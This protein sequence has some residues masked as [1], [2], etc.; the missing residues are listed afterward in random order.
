MNEIEIIDSEKDVQPNDLLPPNASV[1]EKRLSALTTS[2]TALPVDVGKLWD[3]QNCQE[4]FLP[5]LAWAISV[6]H[7]KDHWHENV[8]RSLVKQSVASHKKRGTRAAIRDAVRLVL[9]LADDPLRDDI[10]SLTEYDNSFLLREWWEFLEDEN[11]ASEKVYSHRLK[12]QPLTFEI[13]LLIGR[14][15]LGGR[16]I[17]KPEL[18]R[19][20]RRAVDAVRPLN[21]RYTL[22]IGGA[23]FE[24]TLPVRS[25]CRAIETFNFTLRLKYSLKLES[26]IERVNVV[27]ALPSR[28]VKLDAKPKL[29]F[30]SHIERVNVVRALP[31]RFVRLNATPKLKFKKELPLKKAV[32]STG[33]LRLGFKFTEIK[34]ESEE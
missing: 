33:T 18:Y 22:S 5:W 32:R 3:A 13:Q 10:E 23:Q 26:Q 29:K 9:A 1:L 17:L 2:I 21:T 20:L 4:S 30:E 14:G 12:T 11:T 7:W 6:E 28:F 24:T 34:P 25:V 19:D 8:K 15:V 16:G 27:R 31:S